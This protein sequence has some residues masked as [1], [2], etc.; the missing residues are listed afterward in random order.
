MGNVFII[1]GVSGCGKTTVGRALA[2]V[3]GGSFFDGDDYHSEA[4]VEQMRSGTPLSDADR[5]QWLEALRDLARERSREPGPSFLACSALKKSYRDIL[6]SGNPGLRFLYLAGS[7]SL[8]RARLDARA[9]HYMPPGLL[10]SQFE[11][12]EPPQNAVLI[13]ISGGT[14]EIVA[15]ILSEIGPFLD[16]PV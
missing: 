9:G 6:R 2:R 1:M 10:K 4:N 7:Q 16:S 15:R 13:D 5:R 12:L 3:T 11:A 14:D 8:I